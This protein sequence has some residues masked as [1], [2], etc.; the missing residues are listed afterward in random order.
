[1]L[2]E[3]N[4]EKVLLIGPDGQ[5]GNAVAS[6][7]KAKGIHA[8]VAGQSIDKLGHE[9]SMGQSYHVDLSDLPQLDQLLR[10]IKPTIIINPAAYT[11]VDK[12]ETEKEL[13]RTINAKA[14]EI[15][16]RYCKDSGAFLL[17]YST[18]YVFDGSGTNARSE[19]APTN[20]INRYGQSKLEGELAIAQSG[21]DHV[22]LRTS[23]VFSETGNNF[24]KT[25][26]KLGQDREELRVVSDQVG[27]PTSAAL[28]ARATWAVLEK[29]VN[30]PSARK[31]FSGIYH[32]TCAGETNWAE[33]AQTIFLMAKAR[34]LALK[35]ERVI[36]IASADYPTPAKRPLNSRLDCQAFA[37]GFNCEPSPWQDE[38][39][40]TLKSLL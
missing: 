32:C 16:A 4:R 39:D 38:L 26:L 27:A 33:F 21:C 19:S 7:L 17:H 25:M 13:A 1:M 23:W 30:Q 18:D 29:I 11:A 5:V 31:E 15:M 3:L 9:S 2:R 14:P 20:P 40:D 8:I 12:A 36:P 28:L 24:V 6:L 37:Q 22:I 10:S 35:V 34:K